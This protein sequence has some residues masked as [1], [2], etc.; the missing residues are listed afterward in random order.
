M[1]EG[2]V[3][4]R[5]AKYAKPFRKR[6]MLALLLLLVGA[7]ADLSGPFIAKTI[8]DQHILAIQQDWY[9]FDQQPLTR[10][11][12]PLGILLADKYYVREDWLG[13]VASP[14]PGTA[15][16]AQ[17]LTEGT[18]YYLLEEPVATEAGVTI[19][20]VSEAAGRETVLV[21][22][23]AQTVQGIHLLPEEVKTLYENDVWPI[24][25]LLAGYGVLVLLSAGLNYMQYLSLQ[26]TAQRIIQQM[27]MDLFA[28]LQKL[29]VA[30]F[31]K[32]PVGQL[33]SR[34]TN[35]TEAIRELYV[36]V[37][38]TFVQNGVYMVGILVALFIL[39]P[40]LAVLCCLLLPVLLL[41][42]TIYQKFSNRFYTVIRGK[43]SEMN[44]TLNEMIQNMMVVQAFRRQKDMQAEFNQ[45][46]RD[47]AK[48]RLQETN[49]ESFMLRPAVDLI[50]KV[51]LTIIIWYFGSRSLD[52]SISLG[53]LYAFV[54]YMSRFFEPVNMIMNRFS[55]LQ[56]AAISAQRVFAVLDTPVDERETD[57]AAPLPR[58]KG[59]VIFER[60]SFAYLEDQFVLHDV[61]FHA[62][63]GQ[64]IALV[65]HTG[66]GKSSL[67]NLLLG[68]YP[69]TKGRI[70]I[71]GVDLR[72]LNPQAL[73]EHFGL[74]LQDPFLFT[75]SIAYNIRLYNQQVSDQ[76]VIEA[77]KAVKADAF[78]SKLPRQY[79][80]PVVERGA[81]LSA[82]QRQL[83]SFA[84]ALVND[85]AILI[86][87]EATASIDSETEQA[88]QE[89]L[90]VLSAGRTTF[91]IAHRLSTI[92]HADQIL[93]L[94]RGE[95]AERG[96][97]EELMQQGGIYQKMYQLQLG[98][99]KVQV[100]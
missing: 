23:G 2:R 44:G 35:D 52:D 24:A 34:V 28:H 90:R 66:S 5:L 26:I 40:Q 8:I 31:D 53:A 47:Y 82:G 18:A 10:E 87:D 17:V 93:V 19:S 60:V 69:A 59:E 39:Q 9:A 83:L 63:P 80:E 32:T 71:D 33:V 100:G 57:Y 84:R 77:A 67:M 99:G 54:D 37:L 13:Q 68:F 73:R 89:A 21:S 11:D 50:W 91:I 98:A 16:K 76:Q 64:T 1:K 15:H 92:Q 42:V 55:Q 12:E 75:G 22:A 94:S 56:Q 86:L 25:G 48:A 70:L 3:W 81:T 4:R 97:H 20:P 36:S 49:L 65:G 74:V 6:I 7:S 14:S 43:L 61:S 38:A 30:F 79:E 45:I 27:R 46:N 95:I 58:P 62:K 85:P 41:L 29:S 88:I 96:T 51:S 78:I 72:E